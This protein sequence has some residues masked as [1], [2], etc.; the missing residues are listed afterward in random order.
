M[1]SDNELTGRIPAQLG[2]LANLRELYLSRNQL[3]G[4]IPATLGRLNNL[5]RLHMAANELSGSIPRDLGNLS[6][7]R[8]LSMSD[9]SLTGSIP[10]HLANLD[11]LTHLYLWGNELTSGSFFLHLGDM[12]SLQFLDIGGN[13]IAGAQMLPELEELD[14]LTG[15][16][17]HDSDLTDDDL[18]DYMDDFQALD[19]EFLNLRSN[20]LS[21]PQI[22][23]GLSRITTLQRL[24]INDND[25]SGQLPRSMT[26]LTLMRILHFDDNKGLCAPA[27]AEFQ[28]W[29]QS[30]ENVEGETCGAP[31]PYPE[32]TWAINRS[33]T[34]GDFTMRLHQITDTADG[35]KVD[36]SYETDLSELDYLPNDN[37]TI[38]YPDG[39]IHDPYMARLPEEGEVIDV[40]LGGFIVFDSDLSASVDVPLA[41]ISDDGALNPQPELLVGD[42]RYGVTELIHYDEY[43]QMIITIQPLNEVAKYRVLGIGSG[44]DESTEVTLTDDFG[45][46]SEWSG[47]SFSF[48][49]FEKTLDFQTFN[50][51]AVSSDHFA[52]VT[53]FTLTVRGEG[54]IVGP[55]V[56]EDIRLPAQAAMPKPPAGSEEGAISEAHSLSLLESIQPDG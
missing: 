16:G 21:D 45:I 51:L 13:R 53:N 8:Q 39:T 26:A 34:I 40:S 20:D 22:L 37:A 10:P 11:N 17:L 12:D 27:D 52:S 50:F 14:N 41:S 5:H 54:N 46:T 25:F 6:N 35:L 30:I 55:F 24:A 49:P 4:S 2:N 56:F 28:E 9:N 29:L 43:E 32:R 18:L 36:Y 47:G 3:G 1:L 42:R 23:V 7:L 44:L 48:H 19:L 15:L 38:R 33:L 31:P